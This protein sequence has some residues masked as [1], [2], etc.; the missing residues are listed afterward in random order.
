MRK[1][2]LVVL[3][4]VLACTLQ[5]IIGDISGM[6]NALSGVCVGIIITAFVLP[7]RILIEIL[8]VRKER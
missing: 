5:L 6:I 2:T 4:M 7:E 3:L 8:K 1:G